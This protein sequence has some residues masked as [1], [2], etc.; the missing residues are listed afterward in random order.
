[1]EMFPL[2]SSNLAAAG[3]DPATQVL[4]VQFKNG[5][6]YD[7]S[8]VPSDVANGLFFADSAGQYLHQQIKGK[9]QHTMI[10]P[11]APKQQAA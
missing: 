4:R 9:Y 7:Y 8:Q 2:K 10:Q 6:I 3:Y 1:M 5:S 11:A